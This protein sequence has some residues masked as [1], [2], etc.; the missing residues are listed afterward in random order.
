[1]IDIQNA[2]V[3]QHQSLIL[4]NFSLRIEHGER[5]ALLGPNGAGK[6]TLLKL[7]SRELYPVNRPDSHIRLYGSDIL[8][9]WELRKQIGFVSSD[10]QD[11][12]TPYTRALDVVISGFFGS[13]GQHD[14]LR[15]GE[16]QIQQAEA[17]L[18]TLGMQEYRDQMFQRLSTGQ[19]RRLLLGRALIHQPNALIM[20]E[21]ASGLDMGAAAQLLGML[22][23][24]CQSG[25]SLLIATHHISEVIPEVERVILLQNGRVL[26][27]GPKH[28][29]LRSD[30]LSRLYNSELTVSERH[31][32]Y[33]LWQ[34]P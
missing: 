28:E 27:D 22:R 1:M 10:L 8:P 26:A 12:Y 20:D 4:D 2:S 23:H 19:K 16:D 21:P 5:V 31:G 18:D 17:L 13:I 7:I 29:V 15:P 30:M 25:G 6:S 24:F 14:H 9:L 3:Y 33:H 11:D 34:T 32:W